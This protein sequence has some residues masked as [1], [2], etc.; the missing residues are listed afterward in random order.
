MK[1]NGKEQRY[2]QQDEGLI[3]REGLNT[4]A[5]CPPHRQEGLDSTSQNLDSK[6]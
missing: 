2:E 5:I 6:A 3:P 4:T 1:V